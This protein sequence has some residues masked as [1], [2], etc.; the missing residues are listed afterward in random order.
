MRDL[1]FFSQISQI[2]RLDEGLVGVVLWL[3]VSR[4]FRRFRRSFLW[5][6]VLGFKD[7]VLLGF[8][9]CVNF[10]RRFRRFRRFFMSKKGRS[11]DV[12]LEKKK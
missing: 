12:F 2:F 10:S 11:P 8:L 9:V 3:R 4:R 1:I 6:D 5:C 7:L